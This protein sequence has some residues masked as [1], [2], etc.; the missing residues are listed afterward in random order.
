MGCHVTLIE[1]GRSGLPRI[2]DPPAAIPEVRAG[3]G[4]VA[5]AT[6]CPDDGDVELEV[7]AGD[8]GVPSGDWDVVFDAPL[9]NEGRG[10]DAGNST[11][12]TFHINARPGKYRVRAEAHRDGDRLIDAVRFVF[13]ETNDLDGT[14]LR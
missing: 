9:Q 3:S 7:W 12:S 11:N 6:R 10:F 13:P 14:R 5:V 8:P 4:G 2:P 1:V